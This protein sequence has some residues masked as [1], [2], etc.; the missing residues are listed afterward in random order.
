MP[1]VVIAILVIVGLVILLMIPNIKIVR[2]NEVTIIE[3][4]GR[5]HKL[6]DIPGIHFVI[7]LVDRSI[8]TVSLYKQHIH[9]KI[10]VALG[11]NVIHVEINYDMTITDPKVYVYGS[12]DSN[13]TI[14]TFIKEALEAQMDKE[15]IIIQTVDYAKSY[16][17][18][19]ENIK[20]K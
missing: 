5:F 16:G 6:L 7:P 2:K 17:F 20:I 18:T 19:M 9:K 14:H 13:E 15:E 8:Q 10:S 1:D 12:I 3:R 4:L 11:E